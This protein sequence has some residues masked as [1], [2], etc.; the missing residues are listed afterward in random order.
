MSDNR[1]SIKMNI[2]GKFDSLPIKEFTFEMFAEHPAIILIAKRASGKS[3]V[4]RALLNHFKFIPVGIIICP[5]DNKTCWYGSFFPETYIY[6]EFKSETLRKLLARQEVMLEVEKEK[7]QKGKKI[8]PRSFLV[9]DDCLAEKGKWAN[10]DTIREL[11]MNGRHS[12]IMFILTMQ[13]AL[14][15]KPELRSNFDYI[16][17][18][19]EDFVTNL[20]RIYDHYAGMF[21]TFDSFRQI[22]SQLTAN[23]GAMVISNRGVKD[24]FLEKIFWYKAP[25]LDG[26]RMQF[27]CKQFRE[28]HDKN[29][30]PNWKRKKQTY[31]VTDIVAR[32]KKEK[33]SLV[34][35]KVKQNPIHNMTRTD[36]E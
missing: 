22:F 33:T 25:N 17:L 29:Y 1:K 2:G 9:M 12:K 15:I 31:S 24:S 10:D 23:Y 16:F 19:A 3:W 5:S 32:S 20:K 18:L 7:K 11:L 14:G 34:I 27:G 13:Y 36:T 26:V 28:F 21:P 8:D 4:V 6:Y 30:D 35:N